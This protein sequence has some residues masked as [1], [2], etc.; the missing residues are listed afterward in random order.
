MA[1]RAQGGPLTGSFSV[2][3]LTRL[4]DFPPDLD[5]SGQCVGIIELGGGYQKAD[6]EAYLARLGLQVPRITAVSV[7]GAGNSPGSA[8]GAMVTLNVEIIA[9]GAPGA[10]IAVYFAPNTIEG[11][12]DAIRAATSDTANNPSVLCVG[13]GQT[14]SDWPDRSFR[15]MNDA[16]KQAAALGIT[17][18]C[19]AGDNGPTDGSMDGK[20]HV[21]FPAAS[22]HVLACG[23]TRIS[24]SGGRIEAEAVWNDRNSNRASGGG[25]SVRFPV[26]DWQREAFAAEPDI[27]EMAH[28]RGVPDV[29]I[30]GAPSAGY[31]IVVGGKLLLIGGSAASTSLWSALI[32]RLSQGLGERIGWLNPALYRSLGPAKILRDVTEG[33]TK[34]ESGAELG[35]DARAGWDPCTGWGTPDG[36][37]LLRALKLLRTIQPRDNPT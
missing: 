37:R 3:D 30:S 7:N 4:Y 35:Y 6:I 1:Q 14:E 15:A 31:Q 23:S 21:R 16:L 12:V 2:P 13:W 22:P 33:S 10:D 27:A 29:A 19:A 8:A 25:F 11:F 9:A 20:A 32:A 28:G 34:R 5:G 36:R 18:C 17:V 24:A 26:P